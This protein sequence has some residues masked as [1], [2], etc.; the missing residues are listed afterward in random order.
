MLQHCARTKP[1]D[2]A[3]EALLSVIMAWTQAERGAQQPEVLLREMAVGQHQWNHF[4]VGAPPILAY[5]SWDW[6]VPWGYD[7][8]VDPWPNLCG[9]SNEW[10]EATAPW[11][12]QLAP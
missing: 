7:L 8:D 12:E 1:P 3:G 9:A 11:G 10:K 4:G 6:H 2:A 5:F